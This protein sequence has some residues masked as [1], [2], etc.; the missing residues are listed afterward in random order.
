MVYLFILLTII[1]G[2]FLFDFSKKYQKY[3]FPYYSYCFLILILVAGFR[4]RIGSDTISYLNIFEKI[5]PIFELNLDFFIDNKGYEPGW[6]LLNS[7]VKSFGLSFYSLQ[8]IHAIFLNG[9]IGT[10]IWRI[11]KY[12]YLS[13]LCYVIILYPNLNFEILRQSVS[14]AFFIWGYFKLVD[15]RY[16]SYYILM[17]FALL[18]HYSAI[19]LFFIPFVIK[20]INKLIDRPYLF[21]LISI[22]TYA[23][24]LILKSSIG[25]L[26]LLLPIMYEKSFV[27]FANMEESIFNISFVLNLLLNVGLPI[28]II[29]YI[30]K[31]HDS[32]NT[33]AIADS[34]YT[35]L[36]LI[37][38]CISVMV[39]CLA[40]PLP[41][42]YRFNWYFLIFGILLY[43]YLINIIKSFG[44]NKKYGILLVFVILIV[45]S[46]VYLTRDEYNLATYEKYYP[47]S[48]IFYE[49]KDHNRE[50]NF[51][52]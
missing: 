14:I 36:F 40:A 34:R 12:K 32:Y 5:P 29:H 42:F 17:L 31:R 20:Y 41:I 45:K 47:Y 52:G 3:K 33:S 51:G 1:I 19:V 21:L 2:S 15:K 48:S 35:E 24:A 49:I 23:C 7:I 26:M 9:F 37:L 6:I 46:R 43:P 27:Y 25:E 38:C 18:F 22:M 10:F 13:I 4:Y 44:F 39:Y 16:L 11:T 8:I 50:K 30:G 28:Y